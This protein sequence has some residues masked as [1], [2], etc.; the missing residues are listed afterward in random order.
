MGRRLISKQEQINR[1]EED[2]R[3]S[4]EE[5]L[6]TKSFNVVYSSGVLRV[7]NPN[8]IER[9]VTILQMAMEEMAEGHMGLDD[10]IKGRY[11]E[12]YT[13]SNK[14]VEN[15]CN[16]MESVEEC[17]ECTLETRKA[18]AELL[19][20]WL[21]SW[22]TYKLKKSQILGLIPGR[23]NIALAEENGIKRMYIQ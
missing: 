22:I 18:I 23:C 11:Y 9:V 6:A 1:L 20:E 12:F 7:K 3:K 5:V 17:I 15:I 19:N 21:I 8:N 10:A 16:M 14:T 2:V 13:V 4:C